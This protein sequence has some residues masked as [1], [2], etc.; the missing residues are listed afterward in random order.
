MG[1]RSLFFN[2]QLI[3]GIA[4]ND[5]E[6][7]VSPVSGSAIND[8]VVVCD[9]GSAAADSQRFRTCI[10]HVITAN[11]LVTYLSMAEFLLATGPT[12]NNSN[13]CWFDFSFLSFKTKRNE[14]IKEN[15]SN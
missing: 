8:R 9:G 14:I 7:R 2:R 10:D 4:V 3:D 6:H 11:Q 13:F 15:D 5:I 12:D 1:T